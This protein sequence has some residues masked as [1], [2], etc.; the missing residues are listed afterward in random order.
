LLSFFLASSLPPISAKSNWNDYKSYFLDFLN[1]R[2]DLKPFIQ[3]NDIRRC[4]LDI[5]RDLEETVRNEERKKKDVYYSTLDVYKKQLRLFVEEKLLKG[6]VSPFMKWKEF[7]SLSSL[8]SSHEYQQL[9]GWMISSASNPLIKNEAVDILRFEEDFS[10]LL[11]DLFDEVTTVAVEDYKNHRKLLKKF[12]YDSVIDMINLKNYDEF[13]VILL[14]RCHLRER[15]EPQKKKGEEEF[16]DDQEN[17]NNHFCFEV[18]NS[19]NNKIEGDVSSSANS[20]HQSNSLVSAAALKKGEQTVA[21]EGEEIEDVPPAS[22]STAVSAAVNDVVTQECAGNGNKPLPSTSTPSSSL[23]SSSSSSVSKKDHNNHLSSSSSSRNND[24]YHQHRGSR[25]VSRSSARKTEKNDKDPTSSSL[26]VEVQSLLLSHHSSYLKELY[27]DI[28]DKMVQEHEE[29]KRQQKK[30]EDRYIA[31]L[32][33]QFYRSGKKYLVDPLSFFFPFF[34][35][36]SIICM[37][38][39]FFRQ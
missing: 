12:L 31:L 30:S 29:E 35:F 10:R 14:K 7:S 22:T 18:D 32:R 5:L 36:L 27:Q 16:D 3:E 4:F 11:H 38:S 21:E 26:L 9:K 33:E 17:R 13:K 20:H 34:F 19:Y 24:H 39:C 23:S 8:L 15:R 37:V 6:E 2:S 25:S 28:H 1:S